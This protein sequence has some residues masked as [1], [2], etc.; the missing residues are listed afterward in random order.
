MPLLSTSQEPTQNVPRVTLTQVYCM[1]PEGKGVFMPKGVSGWNGGHVEKV[2]PKLTVVEETIQ[3]GGGE[4][5]RERR[6]AEGRMGEVGGGEDGFQINT[7]A[8]AHISRF[9]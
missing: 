4:L 8:G 3:C 9:Q 5:N 7:L 2:S 1:K 6:T